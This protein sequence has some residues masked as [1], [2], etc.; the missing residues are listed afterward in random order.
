M[1]LKK[2]KKVIKEHKQSKQQN[3]PTLYHRKDNKYSFRWVEFEF[4]KWLPGIELVKF[5]GLLF[6]MLTVN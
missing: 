5:S 1:A 3:N 2:K 4:M 6:S